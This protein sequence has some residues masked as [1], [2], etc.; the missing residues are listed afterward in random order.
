MT[1]LK[2]ILT[3]I[4]ME[5]VVTTVHS[6]QSTYLPVHLHFVAV[7]PDVCPQGI[8]CLYVICPLTPLTSWSPHV[9]TFKF[10][11]QSLVCGQDLFGNS[12][13]TNAS[14]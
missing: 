12:V 13:T 8:V 6:I 3:F 5:M 11:Y 7:L 14:T 2:D 10:V 1:L 4:L 9:I